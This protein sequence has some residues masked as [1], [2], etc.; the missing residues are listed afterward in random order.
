LT[1]AFAIATDECDGCS[2]QSTSM[3]V[4]QDMH[5]APAHR[6]PGG[7]SAREL[8]EDLPRAPHRRDEHG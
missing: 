3:C 6:E 7:L 1:E 2:S 4:I 8:L 5:P